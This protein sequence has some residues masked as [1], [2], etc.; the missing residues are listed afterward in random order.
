MLSE[1]RS[2]WA[3]CQSRSRP[4]KKRMSALAP[5]SVLLGFVPAYLHVSI[6]SPRHINCAV[7]DFFPTAACKIP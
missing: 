4:R 6:S 2:Y 7:K 1:T 5:D 3:R